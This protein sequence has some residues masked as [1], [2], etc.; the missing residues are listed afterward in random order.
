MNPDSP[1]PTIYGLDKCDT[2]RK[3]RNWLARHGIAHEFVDYRANPIAPERLKAWARTIGWDRLV[4]RSGTTWRNLPPARKLASSDPEWIVLLRDQPSL[5]RRPV[6]DIPGR[7][8][9]VGFTDKLYASLFAAKPT[10]AS[11]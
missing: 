1:P 2:C 7:D 8:V 9:T 6:L 4:N 10:G 5:V 3:A 11:S